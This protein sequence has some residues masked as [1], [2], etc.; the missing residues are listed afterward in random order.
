MNTS[1]E[2]AADLERRLVLPDLVLV[3]DLAAALGVTVGTARGL[4]ARGVV[5]ARKLAG[6]WVVE[7]EALVHA[8]RPVLVAC[9]DCAREVPLDASRRV[10]RANVCRGCAESL[11]RA[12]RGSR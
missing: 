8:L 4:M 2:P 6:R 11:R 5:P 9:A 3:A 12:A 1:S 10:G 7:R